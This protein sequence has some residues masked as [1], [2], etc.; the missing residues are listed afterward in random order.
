VSFFEPVPEREKDPR[1]VDFRQPEW[2]GPPINERAVAVALNL[3]L[4]RTDDVVAF[5]ADVSVYSTGLTFQV[6]MMAREPEV[7]PH[8]HPGGFMLSH[9]ESDADPRFGILLAD[10]RRAVLGDWG[11]QAG[12]PPEIVF[13][14]HGGHGGGR[15]WSTDVWL[16]PIPPEG[17]VT[18][19]FRWLRE[20]VEETRVEIDAAPLRA[21]AARAEA[22]WPDER[23]ERPDRPAGDTSWGAYS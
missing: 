14:S 11:N 8:G 2:D 23:P 21:A 15:H 6:E 1:H 13:R 7:D 12:A 20:G 17:P 10:G 4:G 16:W 22:L 9:A 19:V 18:F 3:T 5:I